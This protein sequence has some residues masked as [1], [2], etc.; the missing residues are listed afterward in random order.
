VEQPNAQ[1]RLEPPQ[2]FTQ[3]GGAD[4]AASRCFT[5]STRSRDGDKGC[6]VTELF[7]HEFPFDCS[8]YRTTCAD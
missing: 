6:Q 3:A 4:A 8:A 5:E 7:C 1:P 2:R